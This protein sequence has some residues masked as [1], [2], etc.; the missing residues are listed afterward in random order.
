MERYLFLIASRYTATS[1][2]SI[3]LAPSQS[4][5]LYFTTQENHDY[6]FL[7]HNPY[8]EIQWILCVSLQELRI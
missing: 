2:N 4:S 5:Y 8:G 6:V 7:R 1:Q 3:K